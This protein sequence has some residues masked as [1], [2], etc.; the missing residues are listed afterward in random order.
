MVYML[1]GM[2][3]HLYGLVGVR[4]CARSHFTCKVVQAHLCGAGGARYRLIL[5][6]VQL[7]VE[8]TA[9]IGLT[10]LHT[11]AAEHLAGGIPH[12]NWSVVPT[13]LNLQPPQHR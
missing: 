11:I 5:P 7:L 13:S 2:A 10:K 12:Y 6:S 3:H 1:M 9:M 4:I 8:P